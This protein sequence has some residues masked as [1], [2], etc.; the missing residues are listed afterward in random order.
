MGPGT[1]LRS[2]KTCPGSSAKLGTSIRY[3]GELADQPSSQDS[4]GGR[5]PFWKQ[6][7]GGCRWRTETE[8]SSEPK[9]GAETVV[10]LPVWR[11]EKLWGP[12]G[13]RPPVSSSP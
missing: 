4:I 10:L 2:K 12:K 7:A 1:R 5:V 8:G 13:C 6:R 3:S 9:A 11:M